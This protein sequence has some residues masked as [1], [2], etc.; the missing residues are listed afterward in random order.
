MMNVSPVIHAESGDDRKTAVG[1][2]VAPLKSVHFLADQLVRCSI[3]PEGLVLMEREKARW[4]SP[5][6]AEFLP[7]T[8]LC[9]PFDCRATSI[10]NLHGTFSE[11]AVTVV[12]QTA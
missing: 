1:Q 7:C 8:E 12:F 10:R 4:G 11:G 3:G 6:T 2:A 9:Y 5:P